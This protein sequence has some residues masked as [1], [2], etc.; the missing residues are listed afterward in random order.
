MKILI[1]ILQFSVYFLLIVGLIALSLFTVIRYHMDDFL[2][3][4]LNQ[5]FILY[6]IIILVICIAIYSLSKT[7][8]LFKK[9][10]PFFI[11]F[12]IIYSIYTIYIHI[13]YSNNSLQTEDFILPLHFQII[14]ILIINGLVFKMYQSLKQ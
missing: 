6:T 2:W 9:T 14:T 11:L 3:I 8:Q 10:T 1:K 12:S 4:D 7:L 5:L 13:N